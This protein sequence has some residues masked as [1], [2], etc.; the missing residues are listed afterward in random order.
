MRQR[1]AMEAARLM[2]EH[3]ISDYYTAKRK[4]AH[5][6]GAPDTQNMPRNEEVEQAL[7]A[8]HRLFQSELQPRRLRELREVALQAMRLLEP[9]QPRLV[10]SVLSGT[11]HVHSDVNLHLFTDV[12]EEVAVFLLGRQIPHESQARLLRQGQDETPQRVPVYRFVAGDTVIDLTV[13]PVSGLRQA[14]R[15]PV[16]GRPMRRLTPNDLL[17]LLAEQS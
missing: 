7:G 10:G 2:A 13:L 5:Q 1:I 8:Y 14:P 6:L 3:G 16:D 17:R 4:A 9:F 11:A 15:S 12:P